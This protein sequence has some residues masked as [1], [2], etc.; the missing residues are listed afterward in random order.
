MSDSFATP[1]TIACQAPLPIG[2]PRQ[3]FW[4]GLPFPSPRD[5]PNLGIEPT[6]PALAGKFFTTEPPEKPKIYIYNLYT[7]E[8][9]YVWVYIYEYIYIY[10]HILSLID[11]YKI[12]SIVPCAIYIRSLLLIYLIYSNVYLLIPNC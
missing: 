10:L 7:Y 5:S 11:Y 9:I 3:E 1:W 4:N 12:L 6:S 2:F 8:Y